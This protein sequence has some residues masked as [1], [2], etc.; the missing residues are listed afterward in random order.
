MS[1]KN[2]KQW[3]SC[4]IP[5]EM[6]KYIEEL[7]KAVYLQKRYGIVNLAGFIRQAAVDFIEKIEQEMKIE[8]RAKAAMKSLGL[9]KEDVAPI[10]REDRLKSRFDED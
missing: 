7:V 10:R 3:R 8:E 9:D 5:E 6:A 1:Q 4:A 2:P